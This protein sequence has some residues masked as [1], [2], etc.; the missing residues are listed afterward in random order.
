MYV[1]KCTTRG[2]GG[3][4]FTRYLLLPVLSCFDPWN[5]GFGQAENYQ[6]PQI[7]GFE[8]W[9]YNISE[10]R[11][12]DVLFWRFAIFRRG[13]RPIYVRHGSDGKC[14]RRVHKPKWAWGCLRVRAQKCPP[15]FWPAIY[16]P[17]H[18]DGEWLHH[19]RCPGC[20][21]PGEKEPCDSIFL[22]GIYLLN[23][24]RRYRRASLT[25]RFRS[26]D[27]SAGV[28][29][30]TSFW[31]ASKAWPRSRAAMACHVHI[32]LSSPSSMVKSRNFR[33]RLAWG[34]HLR[35]VR[36]DH[37]LQGLVPRRHNRVSPRVRVTNGPT[38]RWDLAI[39]CYLLL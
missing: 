28:T 24:A 29:A 13:C 21:C 16:P 32:F 15:S 31:A 7:C 38:S 20:L 17:V 12:L 27:C 37:V 6:K 34:R 9:I 22:C 2:T 18:S 26:D 5:A 10:H 25:I 36:R 30:S 1:D 3:K 35:V 19:G 14:L 4:T 8:G 23:H 39:I 33:R 11:F